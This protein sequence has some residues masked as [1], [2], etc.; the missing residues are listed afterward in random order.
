MDV[1]LLVGTPSE[2]L[3]AVTELQAMSEID[4]ESCEVTPTCE[5]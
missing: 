3:K 1:R 4:P 2:I 5:R